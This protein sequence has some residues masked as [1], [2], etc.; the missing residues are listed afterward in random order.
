M[1]WGGP[2]CTIVGPHAPH[3]VVDGESNTIVGSCEGE[4]NAPRD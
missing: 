3:Y 4:L 1:S 2:G